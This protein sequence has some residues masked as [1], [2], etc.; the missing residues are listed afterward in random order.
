MVAFI[1]R[2]VSGSRDVGWAMGRRGVEPPT[3]EQLALPLPCSRAV[4]LYPAQVI[5]KEQPQLAECE[6]P[7][8][9]S[10][11]FPR[12]KW[13]R[14]RTQV[15]IRVRTPPLRPSGASCCQVPSI[16]PSP[17]PFSTRPDPFKPGPA[18]YSP[19][20]TS[21]FPLVPYSLLPCS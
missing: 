6:E 2:Q 7:S 1:L 12:E 10:P 11:A 19:G 14:K 20:P 15:K 4:A 3:R 21:S 9:Y 8:I 5:E 18:H 16:P 13:Q 17:A